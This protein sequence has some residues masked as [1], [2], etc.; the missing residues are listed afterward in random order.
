MSQNVENSK[1]ESKKI[2]KPSGGFWK[3]YEA[4]ILLTLVGGAIDTIGFIAL[5]GFFTNHVTGNL[6]MAGAGIV[7]S[8]DDLW[9]KLGALPVFILTV[10]LTKRYIAVRPADKPILSELLFAE[11]L[12]LSAFMAAA[13][14]LG[15]FEVRGAWEVGMTGFLGLMA[16]AIRNT[17][18]KTIMGKVRPTLLMTGN[19][20]QLGIDL[21]DYIFNRTQ[22]NMESLKYSAAVVFTFAFGALIGTLLYLAIDFWSIGP[23][24]LPVLY[25]AFKA[26]DKDY[27]S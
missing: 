17:A 8:G 23:F 26:R 12:F 21:S 18:G 4:S 24:I 2:E 6:V 27:L 16:F 1:D 10:V 11:V 13:L 19:T 9:I 20:T 5:L 3:R 22:C 7:K 15:P 14:I 25:L